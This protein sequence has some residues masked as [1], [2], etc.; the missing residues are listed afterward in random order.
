MYEEPL[1]GL[2][3]DQVGCTRVTEQN[4][5]GY[6]G[7]EHKHED[8]RLLVERL[9]SLNSDG[10]DA[11]HA[12][13]NLLIGLKLT[14]SNTCRPILESIARRELVQM[15]VVNEVHYICQSALFRPEFGPMMAFLSRLLM[16]MPQPYPW[17][18]LSATMPLVDANE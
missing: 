8:Q 4:V 17:L 2:A 14:T 7:D 15:I 18:L 10:K 16:M 5:D 13:I 1:L 12:V 11:K 9:M 3:M 6:H